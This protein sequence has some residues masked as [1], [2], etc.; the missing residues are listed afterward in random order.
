MILTP[1][2]NADRTKGRKEGD[3]SR[4]ES[5]MFSRSDSL[6]GSGLRFMRL[7]TGHPR[8][9]LSMIV[10]SG[11]ASS[12]INGTVRLSRFLIDGSTTEQKQKSGECLALCSKKKER[13]NGSCQVKSIHKEK[14]S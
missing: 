11:L 8:D 10:R 3:L 14:R 7:E 9:D 2:P 6:S 5:V 13:L 1:F 12:Q 4:S